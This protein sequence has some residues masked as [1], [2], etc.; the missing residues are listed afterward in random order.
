MT[1]TTNA[2]PQ[3]ENAGMSEADMAA[4]VDAARAEGAVAGRAEATARIKAILTC[5]EA[6][7][8]E[9]QAMGFAFETSMGAEEA[10]K[11]LGMAPKASSI[12]SIEE[13]AAQEAEFGGDA[14]GGQVNAAEKVVSGWAA[15]V[16]NANKRFG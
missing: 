2:A 7:G 9:A 16:A 6:R 1:K 13:R 5:E 12:A 8:R 14:S 15:A 4:V 11:V 10:I 3:A